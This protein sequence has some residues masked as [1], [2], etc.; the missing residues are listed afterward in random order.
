MSHMSLSLLFQ[1]Y[2]ACL[3][4]LT[5]MVIE[6]GGMWPY[7]RCFVGCCFQDLFKIAC[8]IPVSFPFCFFSM[9]FVSIHVVHPD[10]SIDATT[11][12]Y[13]EF[14]QSKFFTNIRGPAQYVCI[15]GWLSLRLG[16][17]VCLQFPA[18]RGLHL[19]LKKSHDTQVYNVFFVFVF[20]GL[21]TFEG[22]LISK[23]PLQKNRND[24]I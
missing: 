16:Q 21:S 5:W 2:T 18:A 15:N 8:S 23:P 11:V 7:S 19:V 3:V 22:Y 10:S 24:T 1:Q 4:C 20:C 14:L 12:R 17:L 9:H 13:Y 6:F